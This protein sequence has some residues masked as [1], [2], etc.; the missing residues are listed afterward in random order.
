MSTSTITATKAFHAFNSKT[1]QNV[2]FAPGDEV[3]E[4]IAATV[5]SHVVTSGAR[6]EGG[7]D[8][9][10]PQS[11][12]PFDGEA[13]DAAVQAKV[14]EVLEERVTA[15]KTEAATAETAQLDA[16]GYGTF[17][18]SAQGVK[19]A[20]VKGYLE[21]LNRETV[22]GQREFARVT[23]AEKSGENRSTALVD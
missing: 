9:A 4:H 16:D 13:F 8:N 12:T 2:S 22:A 3:P 21:G 10:G 19:A 17:D 11:G 1:A 6:T 20:D 7:N 23:D 14:D 18:P 15:A 5:G